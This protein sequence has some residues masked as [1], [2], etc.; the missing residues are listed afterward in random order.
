MAKWMKEQKEKEK[1][2]EKLIYANCAE[3][4]CVDSLYHSFYN[5][6]LT[7]VNY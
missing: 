6:I 1:K 7:P 4:L 3:H 5:Q 2:N